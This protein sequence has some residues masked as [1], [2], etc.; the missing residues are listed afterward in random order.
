[1]AALRR[2]VILLV[3]LALVAA[4]GPVAAEPAEANPEQDADADY[5]AV[6]VL[7][8]AEADYVAVS[9]T[10]DATGLLAVAGDGSSDGE[11]AAVAGTGESDGGLLGASATGEASG[12][13]AVS[14]TERA[15]GQ[16]PFSVLGDCNWRSCYH[17]S[18][19]GPASGWYLA[20][21][22]G[23]TSRSQH[24]ALSG[25]GDAHCESPACAAGSVEGPAGG[26]VAVSFSDRADGDLV[27]AS[28]TGDADG[29]VAASGTGDASGYVSA[30]GT[31][32]AG[33]PVGVSGCQ[34]VA[35]ALTTADDRLPANVPGD[36]GVACF[37]DPGA[38]IP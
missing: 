12:L 36:H 28:A 21:S 6:S 20:Y 23:S 4:A 38:L 37:D 32:D 30:S 19:S 14:L 33:E 3:V 17:V 24:L 29:A 1:M 5:V 7:G 25:A 31:G 18:F 11:D 2:P 9:G 10:G 34:A 16:V 8:D 15:G 27:G 22:H 35:A 13:V 26:P